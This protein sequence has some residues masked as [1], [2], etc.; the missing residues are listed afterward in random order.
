MRGLYILVLLALVLPTVQPGPS[1]SS[2]GLEA[3]IVPEPVRSLLQEDIVL[4]EVCPGRPVEY[5]VITCL[6]A[7]MDIGGIGVDDGEGAIVILPNLTLEQGASLALTA[8]GGVFSTLKPDVPFLA[9]GNDSLRWSG[10]F[11]MAD[12]GDE[13]ILRSPDG[14]AMDVVAYGTSTYHGEGWDGLPLAT[15]PKGEAMLRS[16]LDTNTS[17]DWTTEP[18][19]RSELAPATF[20][21]V[22]EPFSAP[23]TAAGRIARELALACTVVN[24]SVY[25]ISDPFIVDQLVRCASRGLKVNVLIEGQPVG[26]LS[27]RSLSAVATLTTVGI[28]VRELCSVDSYKRYDYLHAKY[29]V[30]DHC[31]VTVMSENWGAGLYANRGWGVTM[32]GWGVGAYYDAVFADDFNGPLDVTPPRQQGE[33]FEAT[34]SVELE[35]E[36]MRCRCEVSTVLSPDYSASSL[37]AAIDNAARSIQVEQLYV[38]QEWLEGP[39]LVTSLLEAAKRGVSVRLLLDSSWD[40]DEN[41]AVADELNSIARAQGYDLEARIISSYHDLSVMHNKGVIIDDLTIISSVNWGDSALNENREAG[42]A[43]RSEQVASYFSSLFLADWAVDPV[44]PVAKLPWTY[45]TVQEGRLVLLDASNCSDNAPSPTI[46][47]DIDGDGTV[48]SNATSWAIKLPPGN[49]TIVLTV[50]DHGNNTATT[51]CW[52]TVVPVEKAAPSTTSVLLLAIPVVFIGVIMIWKKILRQ[53]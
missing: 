14:T 31:R 40:R 47:W 25:E 2:I 8:D 29:M 7:E 51:I 44:P 45:V 38:E 37:K 4:T 20:E 6:A 49:H 46:E 43:V 27:E 53:H 11:A 12:G 23:E 1:S 24:C 52:V 15:V 36:D 33:P 10:R 30:V 13:V 17:A 26:G 35:D 32:N 48:D 41:Q 5:V 34:G 9:K 42:V 39:S 50:R 22:V 19:G 18:P 28:D 16:G 21:A 3:E